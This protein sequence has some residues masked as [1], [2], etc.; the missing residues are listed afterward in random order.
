MRASVERRPAD[1]LY[2]DA[3][4]WD[5]HAGFESWPTTDLRNLAIW[6]GAGEVWG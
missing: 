6:R 3:F 2:A 1:S 4:V 5:A